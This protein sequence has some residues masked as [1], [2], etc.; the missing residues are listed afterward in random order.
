MDEFI[1]ED[2]LKEVG[3]RWRQL[4]RQPTKHWT[5]WL[6]GVMGAMT[7]ME[8]IGI[9]VS[10]NAG[11][12]ADWFCWLRSDAAG[13]YSRFIHVRHLRTRAELI[14]MIEGLTG[15]AWDPANHLYGCVHTPERSARL[16]EEHER[17]DRKFAKRYEDQSAEPT[18]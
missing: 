10:A 3:F 6:G 5:L 16:R 1:T 12:D 14:H 11:L 8:D 7:D 2:W 13:L 17:V 15:Q 18:P 9:E 4:E